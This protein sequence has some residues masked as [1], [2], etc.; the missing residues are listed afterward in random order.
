[1]IRNI[2]KKSVLIF[3]LGMVTMVF[4]LETIVIAA[5]AGTGND[6]AYA[7][8]GVT[9]KKRKKKPKPPRKKPPGS[10]G[11]EPLKSRPKPSSHPC[12]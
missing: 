12:R 11:L 4:C 5:S 10:T 9:Q 8:A 1:M 2:F 7:G 3:F 6:Y